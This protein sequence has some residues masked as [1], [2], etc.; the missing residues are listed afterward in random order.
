MNTTCPFCQESTE[1]LVQFLDHLKK[2][3]PD[4]CQNLA[5]EASKNTSDTKNETIK[6]YNN[7]VVQ[8]KHDHTAND[9]KTE[10]SISDTKNETI[11]GRVAIRRCVYRFFFF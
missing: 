8:D 6:E 5:D 3:H 11:A 9:N 10:S 7:V 4:Q 1:D 2:A